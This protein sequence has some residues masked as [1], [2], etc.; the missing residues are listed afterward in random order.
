MTL[1]AVASLSASTCR[2][3]ERM[4]AALICLA[5]SAIWSMSTPA[6]DRMLTKL[7]RCSCGCQSLPSPARLQIRLKLVRIVVGQHGVPSGR[8]NTSP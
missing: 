3:T 4:P 5:A 8:G 2:Q 6:S 7:R 1:A